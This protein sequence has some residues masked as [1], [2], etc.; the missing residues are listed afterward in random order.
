MANFI[1]RILLRLAGS[2]SRERVAD[3]VWEFLERPDIEN[4]L[5]ILDFRDYE[6]FE[7]EVPRKYARYI[8]TFRINDAFLKRALRPYDSMSA[9]ATC[10]E[11]LEQ[12]GEENHPE[13]KTLV[14]K[15]KNDY[16][17]E[18]RRKRDRYKQKDVIG[19][20][21]P[22]VSEIESKIAILDALEEDFSDIVEFIRSFRQEMIVRGWFH[23]FLD[24]LARF[25]IWIK[26]GLTTTNE[27]EP[28]LIQWIEIIGDREKRRIGGATFYE[29]LFQFI[30][31]AGY[32]DVQDLF[33]R[34]GYDI[35]KSFYPE[36]KFL[37]FSTDLSKNAHLNH[38]NKAFPLS[39]AAELC[40]Q[41]RSYIKDWVLRWNEIALRERIGET[42]FE[43]VVDAP[44]ITMNAIVDYVKTR[45]TALGQLQGIE[46]Y[47]EKDLS[48]KFFEDPKTE[49]FAVA[50]TLTLPK[51]VTIVAFR[52]TANLRNWITNLRVDP[53]DMPD[54][55]LPDYKKPITVHEG[56]LKATQKVQHNINKYLQKQ[57][58]KEVYFTG[59]SLGGGV[60]SFVSH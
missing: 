31:E 53:T 48:L 55:I 25:E 35:S 49:T 52:G 44:K 7:I 12:Y 21:K 41:D 34:F 54:A 32:K 30:D 6:T 2:H 16:Q 36:A 10:I 38:L 50:F 42:D 51:K 11:Q 15:S 8:Q 22:I 18:L 24:G 46:P 58:P 37:P 33:R 4:V 27:L 19:C 26:S 1:Q 14:D 20:P 39:M 56:F 59:H 3:A 45:N 23:D 40:Y 47:E 28:F 13:S 9:I 57:Q 43:T 60:S 5:A 29:S 17:E